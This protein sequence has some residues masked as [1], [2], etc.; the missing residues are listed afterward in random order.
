VSAAYPRLVVEIELPD[1]NVE[2]LETNEDAEVA[3]DLANHLVTVTF[4]VH[5]GDNL[6]VVLKAMVGRVANV[7][8]VS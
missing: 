1:Y 4:A 7:R 6:G 8:L 5:E 2:G 3:M